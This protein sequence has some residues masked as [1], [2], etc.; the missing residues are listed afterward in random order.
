MFIIPEQQVFLNDKLEKLHLECSET[1]VYNFFG[2][3]IGD[4]GTRICR[5][6]LKFQQAH[7][8]SDKVTM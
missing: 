1:T 7:F 3:Q 4:S 5:K 2:H 8:N 6:A